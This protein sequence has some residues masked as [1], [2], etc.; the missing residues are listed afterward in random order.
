ME[1]M[2]AADLGYSIFL[3]N[4]PT[5]PLALPTPQTCGL[6]L[7]DFGLKAV[8]SPTMWPRPRQP[9]PQ[10]GDLD[11]D[12]L[13]LTLD[14]ANLMALTSTSVTYPSASTSMTSASAS[15]QR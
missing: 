13:E 7:A 8:T 15:R 3:P 10:G 14:L 11:L 2:W 4:H 5:H 1:S 9:Q 6:N 12:N